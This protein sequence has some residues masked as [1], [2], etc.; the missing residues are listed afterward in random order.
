MKR[1]LAMMAMLAACCFG[2]AQDDAAVNVKVNLTDG[3]QLQGTLHTS[4]LALVTG[5]GKKEIPLAQIATLDF[6]KDGVKVNFR[7]RDVLSGT[8][9]GSA[10]VLRTIFNDLK[11][12]SSQVKSIQF[13]GGQNAL[14]KEPGLLLHALLDSA[15][16]NLGA[17]NAYMETKDVHVI[18]GPFGNN[19]LLFAPGESNLMI[20]LPF[21]PY[22]MPEGMIEFWAKL[23]QPHQRLTG[24]GGQP[25]FFNIE[26]V[27]IEEQA[28]IILGFNSNNGV[29]KGGLVGIIWGFA[30]A[31]THPA[32]GVSSVA[33]T[34]VLGDTPD[35]W[36]HYAFIWKWDG[37]EF[38]EPDKPL[39]RVRGLPEAQ[40]PVLLLAVDGKPIASAGQHVNDVE[41]FR[42]TESKCRF[43]IN[44][45]RINCTS[46]MAMSDLKIWDHAK[47]PDVQRRPE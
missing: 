47:L 33:D 20:D 40:T 44:K 41:R 24:N 46:P 3:S 31:G 21:S 30:D 45:G 9:E 36:H 7:N 2:Q 17:F 15:S 42:K 8:L 37:L 1:L 35:G 10:F 26:R 27:D 6:A 23:P 14:G 19:A 5:F 32:G 25:W 18:E 11:L 22:T 29:G 13:L 4:S 43:F 39:A 38:P 12:D 28:H 34:G 16:E